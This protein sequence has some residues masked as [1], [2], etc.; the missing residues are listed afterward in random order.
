MSEERI[1]FVTGRLAEVSLHK[2]L[3]QLA[4]KVGF[5]YD[6]AA[7][8][9]SVAALM[10]VDFVA[11]KLEKDAS[12]DRVLLPGWCGGDLA[13]LTQKFG[14][15][16]ERGPK[17]LFDLP[18]Y[19]GDRDR[20]PADLSRYDI[21]ILAEINHAPRLSDHDLLEQAKRYQAAGADVIDLGCVP[22]ESWSRVGEV[23]RLFRDEG[24]RVSIDSFDRREVELA[25]DAG[26]ELILSGNSSNSEWLVGCEAEVVVIPDQTH[27]ISTMQPTMDRLYESGRAIRIDPILEPI[28]FGFAASLA[29]YMEA[30]RR[31]PKTEMMMGIGNLTELSEVDSA[32]LNFI[33]AA[34]CQELGIRSVLTTEVVNWCRSAVKEF[35]LARRLMRHSITQ[36]VLPKHVNSQLVLMRDPKVN[37][38]G[39]D[40]L[41]HLATQIRD[42]NFRVIVERGEMHLLNRDG[43]WHGTDPFELF[44]EIMQ[45]VPVD[46]S[47]AFYLGY[48][49][50][51]ATTALTLGKQYHQDEALQWGFLTLPERS[52]HERRREKQK[53]SSS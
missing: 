29:R 50:A 39:A 51:K 32:G 3:I 46:P 34:I 47:H 22:D 6:V 18:E 49:L 5:E 13:V 42:A 40:G 2:L 45:N 33:S 36:Q 12:F 27:D 44:D 9:I 37:E 30:R 15:P 14:L 19:L 1:L 10:S 28:G 16:F 26:A 41:L 35:D 25:V 17:D 7:L 4:P 52:I 11:R 20:I 24:F 21:E 43:Y 38:L 23:I 31:W 8:G 53:L 48:E